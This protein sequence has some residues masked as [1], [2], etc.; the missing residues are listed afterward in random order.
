MSLHFETEARHSTH[1]APA[2]PNPELTSDLS[3]LDLGSLCFL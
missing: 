3:N 1:A 2:A